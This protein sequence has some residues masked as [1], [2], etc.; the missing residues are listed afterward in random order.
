MNALDGGAGRLAAGCAATAPARTFPVPGE[1][2][3]IEVP[4]DDLE[5]LA[6]SSA[7][8]SPATLRRSGAGSAL[9]RLVRLKRAGHD[10]ADGASAASD[11]AG[12]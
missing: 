6:A 8:R 5:R 12:S 3:H 7:T 9:R 11:C 10:P 1:P 2:W 4:R